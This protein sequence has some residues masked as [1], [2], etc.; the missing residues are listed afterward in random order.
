MYAKII[1][2]ETKEVSVGLGTNVNFYK[3]IG[4]VEMD[5]EQAYNGAWYVKGYAPAEPEEEIKK[6]QKQA[7]MSELDAI[8]LKTIRALR[9][10]SAGTG[11]A[12]DKER[13]EE[14]ESMAEQIRAQIKELEN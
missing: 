12:E 11:T 1:N 10:M 7:L 14:L 2:H 6:R 13:L 9:A 3:S 4:M 5:A 8:D